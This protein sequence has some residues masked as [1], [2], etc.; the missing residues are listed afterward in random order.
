MLLVAYKQE[1]ELIVTKKAN[2]FVPLRF[3]AV[4]LS[5]LVNAVRGYTNAE[6]FLKA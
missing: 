5:E 2:Q 3:A 1:I 4:Q 6:S